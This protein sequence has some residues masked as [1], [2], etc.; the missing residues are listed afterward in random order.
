[1]VSAHEKLIAVH[2]SLE[3]EYED[4]K[5]DC[6]ELLAASAMLENSSNK[7]ADDYKT[8][9]MKEA[10]FKTQYGALEVK[11]ASLQRHN[12]ALAVDNARLK[13]H[14]DALEVTND[15]SRAELAECKQELAQVTG[16][17]GDDVDMNDPNHSD[18][19]SEHT[20]DTMTVSEWDRQ[21]NAASMSNGTGV[22][23]GDNVSDAIN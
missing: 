5:K 1:M 3:R 23:T 8:L 15:L 21:A 12:E 16:A 7:I 11:N 20:G 17:H 9:D 18:G 14:I 2:N 4:V 19:G 6:N 10:F 22:G 13:G